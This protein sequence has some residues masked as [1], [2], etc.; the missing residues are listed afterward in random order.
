MKPHYLV[1]GAGGQLGREFCTFFE[2]NAVSYTGLTSK[3]LDI[4]DHDA[5]DHSLNS[6][7]PNVVI[8]CAA[9]T[10]VDKAEDDKERC[11]AVNRDAV[12]SLATNC[13]S[14]GI[15]LVHF[16]TDYVFSGTEEDRRTFPDG[17]PTKH[18]G[19]PSGVYGQSKWEGEEL[20]RDSGVNHLIIRVAWLCGQF[21][22][23]FVKTMMRLGAERDE[24]NVVSDQIG[25]PSFASPVVEQTMLLLE[26]D[27]NGT[28]HIA[29][30]GEISW[31]DFAKE[32]MK[33]AELNCRVHAIRTEDYPTRAAR[34][35]FSRLDCSQTVEETSKPMGD[36]K[37]HL[38]Q[39]IKQIK[40]N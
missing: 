19:N 40:Q 18:R 22:H 13:A 2:Q 23:N 38:E 33:I 36:W 35:R 3:D 16:S 1:I 20:I 6:E 28:R 15:K 5:I 9:Y 14:K 30:D 21:G 27:S 12:G 17:Y 25:A 24:L 37:Q 4:T 26:K 8:N 10:Q 34:P 7:L 11:F 39:L 31:F 29:S 32:T